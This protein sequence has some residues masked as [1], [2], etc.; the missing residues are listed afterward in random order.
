MSPRDA[1][2]FGF[3][4]RCADENL[5]EAATLERVKR[6]QALL[7]GNEKQAAGL[8]DLGASTLYNSALLGLVGAATVGG[9]TGWL[10]AK[11]TEPDVTAEDEKTRELTQ[12]YKIQA[13]R[14]RQARARQGFRQKR[15]E[16]MLSSPTV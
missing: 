13:D 6:A 9:A 7:E 2:K 10:G 4:L 8:L 12:A 15:P 14:A 5:D 16:F 1:F 3:L 11:A